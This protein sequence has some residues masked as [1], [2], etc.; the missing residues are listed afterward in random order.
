MS[1]GACMWGLRYVDTELYLDGSRSSRLRPHGALSWPVPPPT[2]SPG[3]GLPAVTLHYQ[4]PSVAEAA[5]CRPFVLVMDSH[6]GDGLAWQ[7][8][9]SHGDVPVSPPVGLTHRFLLDNLF[10]SRLILSASQWL[11]L[12]DPDSDSPS[13]DMWDWGICQAQ[14]MT[15]RGADS[16]K[17]MDYPQK[18]QKCEATKS[19]TKR[20]DC[21]SICLAVSISSLSLSVFSK[22]FQT[23]PSVHRGSGFVL[24]QT[25]TETKPSPTTATTDKV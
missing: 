6:P 17:M 24:S 3:A 13:P 18:L 12:W 11:P 7:W 20:W 19:E 2:A 23:Q 8:L 22:L 25:L 21:N 4:Q 9:H 14:Y 16:I 5:I 15:G 10:R 1:L